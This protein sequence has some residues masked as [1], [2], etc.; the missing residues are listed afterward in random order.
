MV[1]NTCRK[2]KVKLSVLV[3]YR[4]YP[5]IFAALANKND[6]HLLFV[7]ENQHIILLNLK[8]SGKRDLIKTK[9]VDKDKFKRKVL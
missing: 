7:L 8:I 2:V 3:D 9:K 5:S 4:I 1:Y 6:Q